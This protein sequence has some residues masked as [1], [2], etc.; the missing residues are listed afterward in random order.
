MIFPEGQYIITKPDCWSAVLSAITETP[1]S[2]SGA[3]QLIGVELGPAGGDNLAARR[4]QL[5]AAAYHG[6]AMDFSVLRR[7]FPP[8]DHIL[9]EGRWGILRI[10]PTD[11]RDP[12]Q[13]ATAYFIPTE[14]A[15]IA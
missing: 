12:G 11:P 1:Y 8:D 7:S 10:E 9:A 5:G 13:P 4:A 14:Q 6:A 15:D 3:P 2:D